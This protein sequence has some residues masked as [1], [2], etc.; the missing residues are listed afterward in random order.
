MNK[1]CS[2]TFLKKPFLLL[3]QT[4]ISLSSHP[5]YMAECTYFSPMTF[6]YLPTQSLGHSLCLFCTSLCDTF[7][8]SLWLQKLPYSLMLWGLLKIS[9]LGKSF[10]ADCLRCTW[11]NPN[12]DM[13]EEWRTAEEEK[14][15]MEKRSRGSRAGCILDFNSTSKEL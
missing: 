14:H 10:F 2:R 4:G 7:I 6:I 13:Y 15:C 3:T 8:G 1:A 5:A 11:S 12:Y 9:N